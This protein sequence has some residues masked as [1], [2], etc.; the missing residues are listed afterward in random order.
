VRQHNK[1]TL[2]KATTQNEIL[3]SGQSYKSNFVVKRLIF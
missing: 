2:F 1:K 3:S